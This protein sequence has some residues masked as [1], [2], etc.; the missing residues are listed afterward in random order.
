MPSDRPL[1]SVRSLLQNYISR[2]WKVMYKTLSF[3]NEAGVIG[4]ALH[5]SAPK[6]NLCKKY[7][8]LVR[9]SLNLAHLPP[10]LV[11]HA[12]GALSYHPFKRDQIIQAV[13]SL[14][15]TTVRII[16]HMRVQSGWWYVH[17][18]IESRDTLYVFMSH[19]CMYAAKAW[20]GRTYF[21]WRK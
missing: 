8:F 9:L 5:K 6:E 1:P 7:Y 2:R 10:T 12:P 19:A 4:G 17:V 21:P 14:T 16:M 18:S 13:H 15:T 20:V 11:Q 3:I